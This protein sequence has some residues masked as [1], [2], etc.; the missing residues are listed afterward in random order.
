MVNKMPFHRQLNLKI[1]LM[2][3]SVRMSKNNCF[4]VI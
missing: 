2:S 3:L 1:V 4:D